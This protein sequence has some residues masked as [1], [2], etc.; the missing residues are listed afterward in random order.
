MLEMHKSNSTYFRLQGRFMGKQQNNGF[1]ISSKN[2]FH[3]FLQ[4]LYS[5]RSISGKNKFVKENA[6]NIN[7]SLNSLMH[8]EKSIKLQDKKFK[9][10]LFYSINEDLKKLRLENSI[11]NHLSKKN[12]ISYISLKKRSSL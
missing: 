5:F 8:Q 6:L 12:F 10:S 4:H 11:K 3:L 1:P 7:S 9:S 2:I